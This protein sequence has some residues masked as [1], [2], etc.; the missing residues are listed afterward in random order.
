MKAI[1]IDMFGSGG[2]RRSGSCPL[3]RPTWA[4]RVI[5]AE[6]RPSSATEG[7]ARKLQIP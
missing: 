1:Q 6:D 3:L 7:N 5:E 4:K 2:C